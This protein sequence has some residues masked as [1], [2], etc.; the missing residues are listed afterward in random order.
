MSL[1]VDPTASM[2]STLVALQDINKTGA[3]SY[4]KVQEDT[5]EYANRKNSFIDSRSDYLNTDVHRK[6]T[7]NF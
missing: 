2:L 5:L 6:T 7:N 1:K 4:Y 3:N